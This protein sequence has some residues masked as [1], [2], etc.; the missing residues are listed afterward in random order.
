MNL[1]PKITEYETKF[2]KAYAKEKFGTD[3]LADAEVCD[4]DID[5]KQRTIMNSIFIVSAAVL[6]IQI[7]SSLA[8]LGTRV[9]KFSQEH[10]LFM[11]AF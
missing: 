8:I 7:L 11:S 1:F 10:D 6:L 5:N 2:L 3:I 9:M 4:G